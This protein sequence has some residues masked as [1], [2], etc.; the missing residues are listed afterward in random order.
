MIPRP[1]RSTRT[2]TLFPYTTLFRSSSI[3][4]AQGTSRPRSS[5]PLPRADRGEQRPGAVA[6]IDVDEAFDRQLSARSAK[7]EA[8]AERRFDEV[9][10]QPIFVR[11]DTAAARDRRRVA[12]PIAVIQRRAAQVGGGLDPRSE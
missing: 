5:D 4:T 2:D 11:G 7:A 10:H 9:Q 1:P 6:R 3:S 12:Q 8:V